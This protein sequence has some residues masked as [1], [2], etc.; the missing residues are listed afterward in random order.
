MLSIVIKKIKIHSSRITTSTLF[1]RLQETLKI[2]FAPLF[3]PLI[4]L[5][6]QT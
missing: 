6:N 2:K 5:L 4:K 3:A 1:T